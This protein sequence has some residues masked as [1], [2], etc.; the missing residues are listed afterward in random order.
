MAGPSTN[1]TNFEEK[2]KT[3]IQ[4]NWLMGNI[5]GIKEIDASMLW[6]LI[7]PHELL[8]LHIKDIVFKNAASVPK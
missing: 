1:E 2:R 3:R 7:Q 4:T 8:K 5:V 6:Q